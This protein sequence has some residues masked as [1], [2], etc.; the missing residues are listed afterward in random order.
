MKT[1]SEKPDLKK[2]M[3]L[4][5]FK[6]LRFQNLSLNTVLFSFLSPNCIANKPFDVVKVF[7]CQLRKTLWK[8]LF[9][10]FTGV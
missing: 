8:V 1:L 2:K 5:S 3:I 7:L 10:E 4:T 9:S 6:G